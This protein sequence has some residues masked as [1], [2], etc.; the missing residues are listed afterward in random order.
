MEHDRDMYP[1]K[2]EVAYLGEKTP[3]NVFHLHRLIEWFPQ[4]VIFYIFRDPIAVLESEVNKRNKPGYPIKK[5]NP[6]Y[7]YGLVGFVLVSWWLGARKALR[8]RNYT[9]LV[10]VSYEIV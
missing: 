4:S 10:F 2:R 3:S 7:A 9:G 5:S 1:S 6:L 8:H